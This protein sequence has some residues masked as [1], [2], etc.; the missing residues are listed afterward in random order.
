LFN[1]PLPEKIEIGTII[2]FLG[3]IPKFRNLNRQ[4]QFSGIFLFTN[5]ARMTRPVKHLKLNKQEWISPLE[6]IY[7]SIAVYEEDVRDDTVY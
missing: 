3:F 2:L 4:S 5:E 1:K 7:M 6:Q